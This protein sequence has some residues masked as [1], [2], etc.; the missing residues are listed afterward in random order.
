MKESAMN[1]ETIKKLQLILEETGEWLLN[2][3]VTVSAHKTAND[4]LTAN[5]LQTEK[6]LIERIKELLPTANIVSEETNGDKELKGLSVVIDPI[7][8]TCNFAVGSDLFG[9]QI[10]VF[11]DRECVASI[12]H[13]P[14][15]KETIYAILGEGAYRGEQRLL[16]DQTTASSDGM[17]YISDY[18]P[19]ISI[20]MDIQFELVKSL[21]QTFLKTRHLGAACIDFAGIAK[22]EAIAYICYYSKLWDIAPGLLIAKEAGA[23]YSFLDGSPYEY[24]VAGLV[25]ANNETNLRKIVD[26]Y[27]SL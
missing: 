18:Y 24:N 20:P 17:L 19:S 5:D 15:Q 14:N 23:Y 21:Q 9:L 7:D 2:Q 4:L 16:I 26:A 6:L 13:F 22:K 11:E 8:G 1:K 3:T 27:H 25:V 10:A 12:L